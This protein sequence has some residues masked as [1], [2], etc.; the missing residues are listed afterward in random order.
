[1]P[2]SSLA[3]ASSRPRTLASLTEDSIL[4]SARIEEETP[5]QGSDLLE[6]L[7]KPEKIQVTPLHCNIPVH[8]DNALKKCMKQGIEKTSIVV[9][10]LTLVLKDYI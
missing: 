1:M 3:A 10:G 4:D 2:T 6:K 7:R 9:E 8:L 5:G